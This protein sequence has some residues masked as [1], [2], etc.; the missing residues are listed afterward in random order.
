MTWMDWLWELI[1]TGLYL[2]HIAL[3]VLLTASAI[4]CPALLWL[5][6][7]EA[8]EIREA[9]P[10]ACECRHRVREDDGPGPVLP[11]VLPRLR[12]IGEEAAE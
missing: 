8:R 4:A 11:R 9:I 10:P 1:D 5:L 2:A 3:V 7:S 12:R 6:L